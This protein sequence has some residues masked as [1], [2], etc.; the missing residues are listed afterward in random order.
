LIDLIVCS[1]KWYFFSYIKLNELL[2]FSFARNKSKYV[3]T[4]IDKNI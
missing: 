2:L 3:F 4:I 1:I